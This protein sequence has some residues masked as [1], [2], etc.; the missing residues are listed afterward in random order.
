MEEMMIYHLESFH[1]IKFKETNFY[2]YIEMC[3]SSKV[4]VN[5]YSQKKNV[6]E[7]IFRKNVHESI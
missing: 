6:Y 5:L 7:S 2:T 1:E 3:I 4:L